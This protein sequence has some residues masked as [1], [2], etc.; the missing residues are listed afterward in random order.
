MKAPERQMASFRR[1]RT[2]A[3]RKSTAN[4]IIDTSA[5]PNTLSIATPPRQVSADIWR[6]HRVPLA[7]P[8]GATGQKSLRK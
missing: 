4:N 3:T 6:Q 5:S 1:I 7:C 2:Q 8:M